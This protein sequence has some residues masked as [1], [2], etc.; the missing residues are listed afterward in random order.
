MDELGEFPPTVLD[1]LRQPLEDA[2]VRVSR[3]RATAVLPC[4]VLLVAATNPCP[5]GGG[6]P[7]SCR[8]GEA[9]K[10]RYLRRLSGPILDRFDLRVVLDRPPVDALLD[11]RPAETTAVIRDRVLRARRLAVDR[12]GRLNRALTGPELDH[13]APLEG[14]ARRLLERELE[15]GRLSGRGLVRVRRV[16]C[17]IA[18]LQHPG[19][20]VDERAIG[21]ALALR[22]AFDGNGMVAA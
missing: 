17:T 13:C 2:T 6:A 9:A 7:G 3:A 10:A 8:C 5:C 1:A 16:A 15:R 20:G 11:E 12:Q 19:A 18:D 22:S 4:D 14:A 21:L